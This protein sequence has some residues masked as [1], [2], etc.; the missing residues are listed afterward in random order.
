VEQS[1]SV[2]KRV[3][4]MVLIMEV[5]HIVVR[6]KSDVQTQITSLKF[7]LIDTATTSFASSS[8]SLFPVIA[9]SF[10][11]DLA[12]VTLSTESDRQSQFA[13]GTQV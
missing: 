3:I 13:C 10:Q 2:R 7:H 5:V 11:R 1:S 4:E 9:K 6:R 8:R 12:Q